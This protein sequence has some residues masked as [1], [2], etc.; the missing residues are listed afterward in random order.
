MSS[1]SF[2]LLRLFSVVIVQA[3]LIQ[4]RFPQGETKIPPEGYAIEFINITPVSL[5]YKITRY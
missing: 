1:I 2:I 3:D 4:I 5:E